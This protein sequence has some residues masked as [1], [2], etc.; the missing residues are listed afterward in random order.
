MGYDQKD[1]AQ[2]IHGLIQFTKN[3]LNRLKIESDY[4]YHCN[5][6]EVYKNSKLDIEDSEI[7]NALNKRQKY[8]KM[9]KQELF[10]ESNPSD[11][12][13]RYLPEE[14]NTA[15]DYICYQVPNSLQDI[16]KRQLEIVKETYGECEK[17][18]QKKI[19]DNLSKSPMA[20]AIRNI[21]LPITGIFYSLMSGKILYTPDKED[22]KAELARELDADYK[23]SLKEINTSLTDLMITRYLVNSKKIAQRKNK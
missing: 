15:K 8:S 18:E 5:I 10:S 13:I 12:L 11:D 6:S 2:K 9:T 21:I 22:L 19:I 1:I 14:I 16:V 4:S 23:D 20:W 3:D 7:V 17:E